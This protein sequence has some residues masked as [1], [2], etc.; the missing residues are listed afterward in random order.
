MRGDERNAA[1]VEIVFAEPAKQILRPM[2][3]EV[4]TTARQALEL[5]GLRDEFPQVDFGGV[6]FGIWGQRVPESQALRDGDRLEIY[7]P[8]AM[9]PREARRRLA[10][11]GRAMGQ[12]D[13]DER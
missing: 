8:L 4:G 13:I 1:R 12:R 6:E 10:A 3:I 5:S 2:K 11:H 9:D 7:R